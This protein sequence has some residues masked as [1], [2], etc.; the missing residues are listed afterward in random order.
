[1]TTSRFDAALLPPPRTFYAGEFGRA[2]GRERRGW[3]QTKCCFHEGKSKTS[4]SVNLVEGH[5]HCFSCGA[6]GGDLVSF[7]MQREQLTFKQAAQSLGAWRE[8]LTNS[9]AARLSELRRKR[10]QE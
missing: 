4:L 7:L 3:A 8:D 9:E 6:K 2:L 10:E 1:M 5:F